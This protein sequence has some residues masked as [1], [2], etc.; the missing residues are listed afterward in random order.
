MDLSRIRLPSIDLSRVASDDVDGS[1]VCGELGK[2]HGA[3][4]WL[5]TA[6]IRS[7][8]S[9]KLNA[10]HNTRKHGVIP[11]IPEKDYSVEKKGPSE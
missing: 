2:M 6:T 4:V 10:S 9:F 8:F 3:H 5:G 11:G 1:S 7:R